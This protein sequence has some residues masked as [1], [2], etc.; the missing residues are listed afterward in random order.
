MTNPVLRYGAQA[1]LYL[2]FAAF[3]GYFSTA[4]AYQHLAPDEGLL[5]LSFRHP[6]EFVTDC[7]ART[8]EELAKLPPQLR[9]QMECPRERSAVHV[10][11]ELD[12]RMLYD[13]TFPPAGLRRDGAASGYHRLPIPAGEH[14]LRVQFN[15][16]VRVKGFNHQGERRMTVAPGQVVLIDF[17][18]DQGGVVIR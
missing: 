14:L 18:P 13:E 2:L 5:R 8:P 10:R 4:P 12:G 16:N 9:A 6:G 15:D 3:I 7:R 11:V 17:I 1:V